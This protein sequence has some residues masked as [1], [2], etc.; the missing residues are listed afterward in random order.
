M[1]SVTLCHL[2]TLS[3]YHFATL[4]T[5][6]HGKYA[7]MTLNSRMNYKSGLFDFYISMKRQYHPT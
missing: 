2:I 7:Q 1:M 3:P 5:Y 4:T 6:T